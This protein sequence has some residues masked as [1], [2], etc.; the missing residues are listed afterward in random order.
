M[1]AHMG[2]VPLQCC[3]GGSTSRRYAT[4][5]V[6]L[7]PASFMAIKS[8]IHTALDTA[9]LISVQV[10]VTV[11]AP[12]VISTAQKEDALQFLYIEI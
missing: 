3:W 11:T 6:H 4:S 8:H 7:T 10:H 12:G 5:N 9:S 1:T 2:L